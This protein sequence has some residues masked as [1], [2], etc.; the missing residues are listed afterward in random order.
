MKLKIKINEA[1]RAVEVLEDSPNQ[2][3]VKI[4]GR[5]YRCQIDDSEDIRTR[6]P[7]EKVPEPVPVAEV[8]VTGAPPSR[9]TAEE[10]SA[11]VC[12]IE[13][14]SP[15]PGVISSIERKVG[16]KVNKGDVVL[17]LEA[18]KMLNDI[19]APRAGVIESLDKSPG[20]TIN[21]DDLLF[22]IR[23]TGE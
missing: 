19:V 3:T 21:V 7:S 11:Q 18:M 8:C 14:R 4:R 13:V 17:Y 23:A 1:V 2:I 16:S 9:M 20:Q 6:S 10:T 12:I 15:L 5:S 22:R